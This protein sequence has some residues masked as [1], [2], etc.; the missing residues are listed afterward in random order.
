MQAQGC[1]VASVIL[2]LGVKLA[3]IRSQILIF[4]DTLK[5]EPEKLLNL[6]KLKTTVQLLHL[7]LDHLDKNSIYFILFFLKKESCCYIFPFYLTDCV[8]LFLSGLQNRRLVRAVS[9]QF[10]DSTC[11]YSSDQVR[12]KE[13]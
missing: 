2:A 6:R 8:T 4:N 5:I 11:A 10:D 7:C 12:F 1:H 9:T 13:F 3:E